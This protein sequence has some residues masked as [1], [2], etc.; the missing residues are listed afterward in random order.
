MTTGMPRANSRQVVAA[1]L[2]RHG[3]TYAEELGIDI[4]QNTPAPLFQLLCAALL[5]SARISTANAT[6]ALH[7]LFDAGLT[8]PEKM[9]KAS[10]QARVDVLTA[11]GYKR[12]DES[13]STM[14]GQAAER[15]LVSYDGDLRKLRRAALFD[16]GTERELLME[17]KG[18]GPVGADIFLREV[19]GVW[20]E[21][22]PYADDRV[23]A[24]AGRLGLG[25]HVRDLA[26]WT[27][28]ARF[29][30]LVAALVRVDLADAY[31]DLRERRAS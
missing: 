29:P 13:T 3:T 9:A 17:F 28:R 4:A 19:Q 15:V 16:A 11:H 6:R 18:I 27:T 26:A 25:R 24:A 20:E 8:T 14:L 23:L 21:V 5:Y 10:W 1:L 31:D 2:E 30:A 22:Y 7:A 12:Y